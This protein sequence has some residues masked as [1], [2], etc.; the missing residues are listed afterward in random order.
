MEVENEIAARRARLSP[1]QQAL[2]AARLAGKA[3]GSL[4]SEAIPRRGGGGPVPLSFAQQRLWFLDQLVPGSP[5]YNVATAVRLSFAVDGRALERSLNECVRRHESLRTTFGR[6]DG[7]PVQQIAPSLKIPITIRD[8][9]GLPASQREKEARRIA[10]EEALQP[11]DLAQ[12]PLIRAGLLKLGE[13]DQVLL[14]TLHHIISDGWSMTVLAREFSTLY[15]AFASG[16]SSPLPELAI[17]YADYAVWQRNWL[18]GD[19]LARQLAY[20]KQQ[21]ADLPSLRLPTDRPRPATGTFRGAYEK[22]VLPGALTRSLRALSQQNGCTLF[23]TMLAVFDALLFRY[24]GQSGIVVGC[25]VANRNQ[26]ELQDLVGFFVNTLVL[27]VEVSGDL[28]FSELLRHVRETALAAFAH[29]ELPFEQ[30]V[31]E[32]AP[33]RDLNRNPLYQVAFQVF[34]P[35]GSTR[36]EPMLPML[37]V[38]RGTSIFDLAFTLTETAEGMLGGIEYST[39]LFLPETIRRMIGHYETLLNAVVARPETAISQHPLLSESEQIQVL[40]NWNA[41]SC[42]HGTDG[43][44]IHELVSKQA[45][46]APDA[47]AVA[48]GDRHLTYG[49]L[50]T[51]ANALAHRLQSLGA[52]PEV[53]VAV[54]LERSIEMIVAL[55]GVLKTGAAYLPLDPQY[56]RERLAFMLEDSRARVVVTEEA[57]RQTIA[58]MKAGVLCLNGAEASRK[59]A[60]S[61]APKVRVEP[62]NLAYVIYTSGSTGTPKGVQI[63]H[64][65]LANLVGWHRRVYRLECYDRA[66]Q[67]ASPVFDASV[68]EIWPYLACGASLHIPDDTTRTTPA[69]LV[70]WLEKRQI[71]ICFLPTPLAEA[72][73]AEPVQCLKKLRAL[74]TGG[75][76]LT[77]MPGRKLPF[78][79]LNHY[80]P[81]E[82]T[83]VSTW[84]SLPLQ[85][86]ASPPIGRPIDNLQVYIVDRDLN[87]VPIGV[88]G[89][90]LI[91]GSGLARGYLYRSPLTAE[92]FIPDPF[93]K[94]PGARLYRTGDLVRY[95]PDGQIEFLGRVDQQVKMRGFRI[96]LGE[97]EATLQAHPAVG[98]VAVVAREDAPSERRLVAYVVQNRDYQGHAP[99]GDHS[100]ESDKQVEQWQTLYDETYRTAREQHD[101][102]T[103]FVGWNSSATGQPIP[104]EEMREWLDQGV[105]RILR[106]KPQRLLEIGCGLGLLLFRV[107]PRARSYLG[108]DF[109]SAAIEY[110]RRHATRKRIGRAQI[111]LRQQLAEDFT[112]IEPRSFDLV[113]LNSIIQYFPGVDYLLRVL[114]GAARVTAD[115]GRIFVGD[116]RSL[117]LLEAF[118][119][120]VEWERAADSVTV[121]QFQERIRVGVA[122]EQELVISPAFFT[123]LTRYLPEIKA[124]EIAPKRGKA[125]NELTCFRYD[126]TLH[127]GHDPISEP[128]PRRFDWSK[129]QLTAQRLE[130]LLLKAGSESLV[131]TGIPN[132]RVAL[133]VRILEQLDTLD[134][135]QSIGELRGQWRGRTLE[136]YDPEALHQ[137]AERFGFSAAMR[138]SSGVVDGSFDLSLLRSRDAAGPLCFFAES[139]TVTA[140]SR[141]ANNPLQ[142]I[143]A[144]GLVPELRSFLS[145]RLPDYMVPGAFVLL[146]ELPLSPNGKVDRAAL[147]SPTAAGAAMEK[148]YVAPRNGVEEVLA[149]LWAEVLRMDRVSVKADFFADLGG[150]SLLATQLISRVRE[151][152]ELEVPLRTLF[153]GSTVVALAASLMGDPR[154]HARV[155]KTAELYLKLG[156]LSDAEVDAMLAERRRT[157]TK[158]PR[159]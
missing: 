119:S 147:P 123:A 39:D 135:T 15:R 103:N 66:T 108:T 20:W 106:W 41:T 58:D 121:A 80:G 125:R 154:T 40:E 59:I 158:G 69:K 89:E 11:F 85:G 138:W 64:R 100:K 87:P 10:T 63:T 133:P 126:V 131:I 75:D 127:V 109:S 27:R 88:A 79:F 82:V 122:Q 53:L 43:D 120:W 148:A 60:F 18:Q 157:G 57:L 141:Q 142:G 56:P 74:L 116:V 32:L 37:D 65:G 107:A 143:F 23:M 68:W 115:G 45:A 72:V 50:E 156:R 149:G 145:G 48:A 140:W 5:F 93:G 51:R 70:E 12:G 129:D 3:R 26:P 76:K 98:T 130:R 137:L 146:E 19:R 52:G 21:L 92:R 38:N 16:K 55:L 2:L 35:P 86:E 81:T 84:T 22:M 4:T 47:L 42:D 110:V 128:E 62:E 6:L 113:I 101:P 144:R 78:E 90:L 83:V 97:I 105:E 94:V 114:E 1:R 36:A 33:E 46:R 17:Q 91:G 159:G 54:C 139:T 8:L 31:E 99:A 150:H 117:S 104:P 9:R 73:L 77:R 30:I 67:I 28:P 29:Q 111:R 34:N 132:A 44:Y 49:E 7:Q 25:P 151:V 24:T 134:K 124:V 102:T 96:E 13:R 152:F 112:G 95:L 71:T 153:E 14:L 61:V 155:E 136:G 118:H